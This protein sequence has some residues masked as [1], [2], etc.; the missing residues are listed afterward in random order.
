M[1]LQHARLRRASA[2]NATC[3]MQKS[4]LP[5]DPCVGFQPCVQLSSGKGIGTSSVRVDAEV[6][7]QLSTSIPS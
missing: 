1:V 4:N 3:R 7:G 6:A 5:L 2:R